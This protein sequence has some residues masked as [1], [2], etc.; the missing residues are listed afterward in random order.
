MDLEVLFTADEALAHSFAGSITVIIDVLRATTTITAALEA[1]ARSVCPTASVEAA[2]I[3]RSVNSRALLCGEREGFR[4]EG[5]DY[6][7]SPLE[8]AK[9]TI[10]GRDLILTTTN[11]TKAVSAAAD[12]R[13]LIAGSV[14]NATAAALEVSRAVAASRGSAESVVVVCSGTNGRFSIDDAFAAGVIIQ[15]LG[16][17]A[18]RLSDSAHAAVTLASRPREQVVNRET[19]RHLRLLYDIGFGADVEYAFQTDATDTV[20]MLIGDSFFV[21]TRDH[22]VFSDSG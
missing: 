7:N 18:I 2:R 5:F 14:R 4:I 1:G 22:A 19:C 15:R 12:A 17:S 13:L 21:G 20:P 6:G 8:L 9:A 11:G 16:D 3:R 10:V